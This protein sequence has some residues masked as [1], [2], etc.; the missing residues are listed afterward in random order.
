MVRQLS[1]WH[2]MFSLRFQSVSEI[3]E[4]STLPNKTNA[5]SQIYLVQERFPSSHNFSTCSTELN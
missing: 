4:R 2:H 5:G 1:T 3:Q